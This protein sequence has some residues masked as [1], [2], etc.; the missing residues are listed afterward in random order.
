[1]GAEPSLRDIPSAV[2]LAGRAVALAPEDGNIWNTLGVARYRVGD[3]S[4]A[5]DALNRSNR[6]PNTSTGWNDLFLGMARFQLGR[7]DQREMDA[8]EQMNTDDPEL[9]AVKAEAVKLFHQSVPPA[10]QP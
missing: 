3:Y 10:T 6:L 1:M 2:E 7:P 8:I 5:I 4:G 9:A